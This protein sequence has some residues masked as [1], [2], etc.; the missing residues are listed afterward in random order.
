[1]KVDGVGGGEGEARGMKKSKRERKTE[2]PAIY[3]VTAVSLEGQFG[4]SLQQGS[5]LALLPFTLL[6][7]CTEVS[8][9]IVSFPSIPKAAACRRL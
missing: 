1:M 4:E 6:C 3:L 8:R 9:E 5:G 2:R 7:D